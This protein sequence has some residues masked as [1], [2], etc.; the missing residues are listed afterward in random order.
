MYA[1]KLIRWGH[2]TLEQLTKDNKKCHYHVTS[3][4][5]FKRSNNNLSKTISTVCPFKN[6]TRIE[7]LELCF[8]IILLYHR[9]HR[10]FFSSWHR[11]FS[12]VLTWNIC[13]QY[14]SRIYQNNGT[15]QTIIDQITWNGSKDTAYYMRRSYLC[16]LVV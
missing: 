1:S 2:L 14:E 3:R 9:V 7:L 15:Y 16:A 6:S 12:F 11:R 4:F 10:S 5:S 13:T 8:L